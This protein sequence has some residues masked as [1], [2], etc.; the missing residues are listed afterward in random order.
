[1]KTKVASI[2]FYFVNV[3]IAIIFIPHLVSNTNYTENLLNMDSDDVTRKPMLLSDKA[4][5]VMPM[6]ANNYFFPILHIPQST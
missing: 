2:C 6:L 4:L 3:K 5:G 1:M